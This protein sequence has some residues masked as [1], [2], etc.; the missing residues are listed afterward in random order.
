MGGNSQWNCA[1]YHSLTNDLIKKPL[2][3]AAVANT[4]LNFLIA[5]QVESEIGA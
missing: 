4:K 3:L 1:F 2:P 5:V